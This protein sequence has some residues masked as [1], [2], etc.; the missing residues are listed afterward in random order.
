MKCSI[1]GKP[2]TDPSSLARGLGPICAARQVLEHS[3]ELFNDRVGHIVEGDFRGDVV[4]SR[5][6]GCPVVNIE[7]IR[8]LHSPTGFEWGY[9]GSG[10]ADLA[11]NV[12]LRF[13]DP[14][15]AERLHQPFKE[16]FVAPLPEDGGILRGLDIEEWL[17]QASSAEVLLYRVPGGGFD[18]FAGGATL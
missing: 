8:V 15:T 11:L 2:L 6:D 4:L 16:K 14:A 7:Q 18:A 13:T 3:L 1:C 12:L 5:R 17:T 10:P 9:C